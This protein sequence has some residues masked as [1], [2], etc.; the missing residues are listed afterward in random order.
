M[1]DWK[2][3]EAEYITTGSSYRKLAEKYGLDQ[4]TIA[5]RAKREEWVSKRQQHASKTQAEII[6][7]D[8]AQKVDRAT[9][10]YNAADDLLDKIVAGISSGSVVSATAAKNYSDA[11]RSIKE[12]HMI[13][14]AEDIEEQKARID[15]LRKDAQREDSNRAITIT[16]EGDLDDYAG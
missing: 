13:R 4:A 14:S 9:K 1:A 16:L 7:A 12:I 8:T 15:K 2:A 6:T 3:I 11:L 5:R 10:L